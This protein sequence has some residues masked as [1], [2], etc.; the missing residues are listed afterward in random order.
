M[1]DS[2]ELTTKNVNR[3]NVRRGDDVQRLYF[4]A[5]IVTFNWS[6][7]GKLRLI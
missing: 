7:Q 3:G 5:T 4:P 1:I 6:F 2:L